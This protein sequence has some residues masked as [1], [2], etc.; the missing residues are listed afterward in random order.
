LD[1]TGKY[2]HQIALI[3]CGSSESPCANGNEAAWNADNF[4]VNPDWITAYGT[5]HW[6]GPGFDGYHTMQWT[7]T[8]CNPCTNT[9]IWADRMPQYYFSYSSAY[10]A[11]GVNWETIF[12]IGNKSCGNMWINVPPYGAP[13]VN[14]RA[15]RRLSAAR[16]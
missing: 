9:G 8:I 11:T 13:V 12:G 10:A 5:T 6:G 4:A 14:K 3:N 7:K 16:R 2:I 1:R 15:V